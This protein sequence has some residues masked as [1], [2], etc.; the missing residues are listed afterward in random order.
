MLHLRGA[1]SNAGFTGAQCSG[2]LR[3]MSG[4]NCF[5]VLHHDQGAVNPGDLISVQLMDGLV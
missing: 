3:S 5:V 4:T 2:M 1:D